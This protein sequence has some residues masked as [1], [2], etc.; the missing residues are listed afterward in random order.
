MPVAGRKAVRHCVRADRYRQCVDRDHIRWKACH[1]RM[2]GSCR[3][4]PWSW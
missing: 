2:A 1:K 4:R 3:N